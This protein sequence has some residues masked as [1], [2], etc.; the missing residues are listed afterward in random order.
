MGLFSP[1]KETT[2]NLH[3][4]DDDTFQFRQVEIEKGWMIEKDA[5][6]KAT[7]AYML[8][9]KTQK[10]FDGFGKIPASKLT[11]TYSRDILLDYF[12]QLAPAEKPE[13]G[14]GLKEKTMS[15]I[16][17]ATLYQHE[18]EAKPTSSLDKMI[19]FTGSVAVLL[20]LSIGF[21]ILANRGH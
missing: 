4:R 20:A 10:Q 19:L 1:V 21:Q 12:N 5:Q 6:G 18:V 16:A 3:F 7:G 13:K 11:I 17:A 14:K 15:A 2:W 9:Y 8:P